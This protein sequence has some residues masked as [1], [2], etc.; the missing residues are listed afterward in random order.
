M[1]KEVLVVIGL[2]LTGL[3]LL[4]TTAMYFSSLSDERTCRNTAEVMRADWHYTIST[5]CLIRPEG[6]PWVPLKS[7]R[8]Y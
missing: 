3:T 1:L 4:T 7:Y 6:K 5:G 2:T 8:V